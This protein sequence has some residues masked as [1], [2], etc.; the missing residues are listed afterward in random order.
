MINH[1]STVF[2]FRTFGL[3]YLQMHLLPTKMFVNFS[4]IETY[5]TI[6]TFIQKIKSEPNDIAFS[7]TIGII[8]NYFDFTPT[9]FH[10]GELYNEAGQNSGSCKVFAFAKRVELTVEETLACFGT[11]Y[12]V[13]VL[14]NPEGTDHQNIRNFMKTGW[15]GIQFEGTPLRVK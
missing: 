10:N 1:D 7:D 12:R 3:L 5:M 9:A 6:S 11:Y 14:Q 13:D 4:Q 15:E 8:D 2:Y